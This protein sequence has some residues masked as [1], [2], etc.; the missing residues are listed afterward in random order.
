[1]SENLKSR[2]AFGSS[3]KVEQAL[4]SKV[5]DER[6]ILF[7]DEDTDNPKIGWITKTG[8]AVIVSNEKSDLTELET[9]LLE[10]ETDID[11]IE[12]KIIEINTGY[13]IVEF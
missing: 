8:Q 4:E 1:M 9:K 3:E 7:L 2:H 13:E 5:I 11:V 12:G 10:L 6:D